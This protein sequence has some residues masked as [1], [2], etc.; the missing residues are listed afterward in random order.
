[1]KNKNFIFIAAIFICLLGMSVCSK[2]LV[3]HALGGRGELSLKFSLRGTIELTG[4]NRRFSFVSKSIDPS[5]WKPLENEQN[6][7]LYYTRISNLEDLDENVLTSICSCD[8]SS[9]SVEQYLLRY[10]RELLVSVEHIVM[11]SPE[12]NK[13]TVPSK[14]E[15]WCCCKGFQKI[16]NKKP[17]EI[18]VK[19][20]NKSKRVTDVTTI[21]KI[22]ADTTDSQKAPEE[23]QS[24]L[25][26]YW[27]F[28]LPAAIMLLVGSSN[29]IDPQQ[30]QQQ[31]QQ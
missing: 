28:I 8:L 31:Q 16:L 20:P 15:D 21:K 6:G 10:E 29:P 25:R 4:P 9:N 5:F 7:T 12:S 17:L 30:Q 24:F 22:K 26:K 2:Y 11:Q 14:S 13:S 19:N 3:E 18:I 1:M 27:Y 23:E